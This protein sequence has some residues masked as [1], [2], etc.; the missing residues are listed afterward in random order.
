MKLPSGQQAGRGAE[1]QRKNQIGRATYQWEEDWPWWVRGY[2]MRK[3]RCERDV[4]RESWWWLELL[5]RERAVA[6]PWWIGWMAW[7]GR[8]LLL[9]SEGW[10]T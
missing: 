3:D 7:W 6:L 4:Q 1:E 10:V 2:A 5:C 8:C 9:S